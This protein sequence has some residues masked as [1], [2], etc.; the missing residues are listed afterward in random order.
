ME[1]RQR[2]T[3]QAE[4]LQRFREVCDEGYKIVEP[5]NRDYAGSDDAFRNLRR[6]GL[7]G[8]LVR[9][10]DKVSRL[11]S[12]VENR[13]ELKVKSETVRETAIDLMNYANIF[14]QMVDE[15]ERNEDWSVTDK[16]KPVSVATPQ[17][18]DEGCTAPIVGFR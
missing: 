4:F 13:G 18:E 10:E 14:V 5:K 6:H 8:V 1:I 2:I 17:E 15:L 12:F 7:Y 11:N 9:I 16:G 3:T